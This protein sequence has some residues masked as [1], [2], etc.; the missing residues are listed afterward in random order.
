MYYVKFSEKRQSTA[1]LF[2]MLKDKKQ[3]NSLKTVK[4]KVK[5]ESNIVEHFLTTRN[6]KT[7][8]GKNF[9]ATP[10]PHVASCMLMIKWF[11]N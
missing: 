11:P 9:D 5:T 10:A 3:L 4:L 2:L 1:M 6:K 7:D 8:P